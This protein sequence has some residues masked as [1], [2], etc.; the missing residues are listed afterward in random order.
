MK[1]RWLCGLVLALGVLSTTRAAEVMPAKPAQYFNDYAGVVSTTTAAQLN[2]QLEDFEK[3]T[4]N[5]VVVAVYPKM[6]SNSSLEDYTHRL[7][8]SWQVGQAGKNNGIVLFVFVQEHR[9]RI[10]AGYGLEGALPDALAKRIEDDVI[11]PRF[12]SGDYDGGL[13]AGITAIEQ[14]SRGEYK[15]SGTTVAG[16]IDSATDALAGILGNILL[17]L[18]FL[19]F[20]YLRF[21]SYSG[22]TVY[23]SSGRSF[24][25]GML[26]G[27][28]SGGFGGG[29]G[30]G[31]S[32]GGG[33]GFS[34]GGGH[35]GGGGAS[36]SW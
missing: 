29:G 6:E 24:A 36:G 27:G 15:G 34:G 20:A 35:F 9:L 3:Q 12:R 18:F 1:R 31:F 11:T 28:L 22:A 5:Q 23:G 14:A 7:A 33:G 19:L 10:E 4:S 16:N 32:G 26:L 30:G 8:E 17:I 13:T 2:S 25:T 21:R